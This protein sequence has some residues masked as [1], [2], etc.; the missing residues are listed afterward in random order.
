MIVGEFINTVSKLEKYFDGN[1]WN[2]LKRKV[3]KENSNYDSSDDNKRIKIIVDL[4]AEDTGSQKQLV[5]GENSKQT[6]VAT[7]K[8]QCNKSLRENY[9]T[10]TFLLAG[11]NVALTSI[12]EKDKNEDVLNQNRDSPTH[13]ENIFSC[14]MSPVYQPEFKTEPLNIK[15]TCN[16]NEEKMMETVCSN[17]HLRIVN[18]TTKS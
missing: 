1:R 15:D 18:S 2:S 9:C 3:T 4:F 12:A 5:D 11:C 10:N 14:P 7:K 6:T 8:E 16:D 17:L 13:F